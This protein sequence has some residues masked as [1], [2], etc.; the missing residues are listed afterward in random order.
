MYVIIFAAV[1]ATL[2]EQDEAGNMLRTYIFSTSSGEQ[3]QQ[4][5]QQQQSS[6]AL[7]KKDEGAN[8]EKKS[9]RVDVVECLLF[10]SFSIIC[11]FGLCRPLS[12]SMPTLVLSFL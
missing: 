3:Q 9:T 1:A 7:G 10:T 8:L 12:Y 6:N 5:Q 11:T 2:S 4:Q